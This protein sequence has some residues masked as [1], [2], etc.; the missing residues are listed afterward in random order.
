M[1]YLLEKVSIELKKTCIKDRHKRFAIFEYK[2]LVIS[3]LNKINEC[4]I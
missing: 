3:T 1:M 2:V 4:T